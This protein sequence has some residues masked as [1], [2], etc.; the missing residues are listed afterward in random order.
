M[1]LEFFSKF[2]LV[3]EIDSILV[4]LQKN[5]ETIIT[6]DP[7]SDS[8]GSFSPS[9]KIITVNLADMRPLGDG[10]VSGASL[11]KQRRCRILSITIKV[12]FI[13]Y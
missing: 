12:I 13:D 5:Y 4:D 9:R 3:K 1:G 2:N 7:K 8:R 6:F 11:K 10:A